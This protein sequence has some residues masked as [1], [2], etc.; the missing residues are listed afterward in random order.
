MEFQSVLEDALVLACGQNPVRAAYASGKYL[1]IGHGRRWSQHGCEQSVCESGESAHTYTC[2]RT[3]PRR[4]PPRSSAFASPVPP[5]SLQWRDPLKRA[6]AMTRKGRA[7][8]G[9][10]PL[11]L[12]SCAR[13]H[14]CSSKGRM[15]AQSR[16]TR[17]SAGSRGSGKA[18]N[19][20]CIS[21]MAR[22]TLVTVCASAS[23]RTSSRSEI[24]GDTGRCGEMWGDT[25]RCGETWGDMGRYGEICCR[26][27]KGEPKIAPSAVKSPSE[28]SVSPM[29]K[30]SPAL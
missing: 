5:R 9:G 26:L 3:V 10:V 12:K 7:S 27:P 24:R 17:T 30:G 6:G 18:A 23:S 29:G 11:P 22:R 2:N 1:K 16:P 28:M 15:C 8:P 25:G 19:T 20:P 13:P 4:H 14:A 21:S